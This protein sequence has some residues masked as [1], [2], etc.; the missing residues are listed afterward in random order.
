MRDGCRGFLVSRWWVH[1]IAALLVGPPALLCAAEP[2]SVAEPGTTAAPTSGPLEGPD[3]TPADSVGASER[4]EADTLQESS[5]FTMSLGARLQVRHR[6]ESEGRTHL[7]RVQRARVSLSGQAY[8]AFDYLIQ[9]GLAGPGVRLLDASIRYQLHPTAF[10]WAGQGKAPFGRQQLTS[11]AALHFVDRSI[12]DVRFAPGRQQGFA[13]GGNL[14]GERLQYQAG[15]FNGNGINQAQNP[16]GGMMTVG[17]VVFTPLG[18]YPPEESAHADESSV[19]VALGVAGLTH[20]E[21]VEGVDV[22]VSRVGGEAAFRMGGLNMTGELFREWAE[23]TDRERTVTDGGHGQIGYL[24]DLRHEV[25]ARYALVRP[26]V[27]Q[28]SA[29]MGLAYS[30][31]LAAHRAKLQADVR[32]LRSGR[33]GEDEVEFRLQFTLAL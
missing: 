15:L 31:Y 1:C 12:A 30:Y 29:E 24:W 8:D 25:A 3:S 4:S 9:L 2:P 26:E 11:S 20:S 5:P 32:N 10:L 21:W 28:T 22:E 6:Y 33:S 14:A 17:R 27:E 19:R 16:G 13:L 18:P 7:T 23:S